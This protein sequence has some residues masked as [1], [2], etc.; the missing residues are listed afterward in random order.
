MK[1]DKLFKDAPLKESR[2]L[3]KDLPARF[4]EQLVEIAGDDGINYYDYSNK[5]IIDEA[6]E[7]KNNYDGNT[8]RIE[9][10]SLNGDYGASEKRVAQKEYREIKKFLKKHS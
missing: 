10:D 6:K 5:E 8:G 9:Q 2:Q 4:K 1:V 3:I 7:F